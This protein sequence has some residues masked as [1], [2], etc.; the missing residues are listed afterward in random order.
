MGGE[1]KKS[2]KARLRKGISCLVATPGRL[3]DHLRTTQCFMIGKLSWLVL[4]EADRLLDLGF[5]KDLTDILEIIRQRT[6]G[7]YE[8]TPGMRLR[9][10]LISAT[11]T[12]Q[13]DKLARISLEKPLHIG[14]DAEEEAAEDDEKDR[15]LYK[16]KASRIEEEA[17][18]ASLSKEYIEVHPKLRL[19]N[20]IAAL[21]KRSQEGKVIVFISSTASCDFHHWLLTQSFPP[22]RP[23]GPEGDVPLL[24]VPV[25]CLH[26]DKP[27]VERTKAWLSFSKASSGVLVCTNVAARGLDMPNVRHVIQYDPPEDAKEF[28]H[29]VG[30]TGRLGQVGDA[31]LFLL[32]SETDFLDVLSVEQLELKE[33][34]MKN[35]LE[36]LVMDQATETAEALASHLQYHVEKKIEASEEAGLLARNGFRSRIRAYAAYPSAVKQIF[37][38]RKLHLG[39]MAK[40][41]GLREQP[42]LTGKKTKKEREDEAASGK[43]KGKVG[44]AK[45]VRNANSAYKGKHTLAQLSAMQQGISEFG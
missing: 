3:L 6:R 13:V 28:V 22:L 8:R 37:H 16:A 42:S 15:A 5:S 23:T 12:S 4:D 32:P 29:Q 34:P 41:F 11:M 2:E 10:A 30:R 40:S 18:P 35:S 44:S 45:P 20:L 43:K 17:T 9:T 1:K 27:Q 14:I 24:P 33:L 25:W 36:N 7:N 31:L 26:G 21:K 19:V 39:H 38:V